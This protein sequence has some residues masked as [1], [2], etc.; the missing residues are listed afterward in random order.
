M[1]DDVPAAIYDKLLKDWF[2][3]QDMIRAAL[4]IHKPRKSTIHRSPVCAECRDIDGFERI[5]PCSTAQA[6]G[7]ES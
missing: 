3:D 4:L 2:A 6:L 1:A 5:Y 7:V